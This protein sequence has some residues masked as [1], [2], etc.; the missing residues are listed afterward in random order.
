MLATGTSS[1]TQSAWRDAAARSR[2]VSPVVLAALTSTAGAA[3]GSWTM[4]G[5][6]AHP[7]SQTFV[8]S[9]APGPPQQESFFSRLFSNEDKQKQPLE[10][11][12]RK[13]SK[14][15]K[16]RA[17]IITLRSKISTAKSNRTTYKAS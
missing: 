12:I 8:A 6:A 16:V 3:T 10:D 14:V 17:N 15:F 13:H 2:A 9:Q 1:E 11:L 7:L 5:P 4:T